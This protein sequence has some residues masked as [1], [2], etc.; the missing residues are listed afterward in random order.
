MNTMDTAPKDRDIL[1]WYDHAADPYHLDE[2]GL[3]TDYGTWCECGD[4]LID[5]GFCIAKWHEPVWESV[6]EYGA[7]YWLPGWWFSTSHDGCDYACNPT[8]WTEL[9]EPPQ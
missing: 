9:P 2:H 5:N 7:G 8:R 4:F 6:D 1:V 3:L